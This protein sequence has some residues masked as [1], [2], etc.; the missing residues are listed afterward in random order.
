MKRKT[1][2][3][4][5]IFL[6][7]KAKEIFGGLG[8]LGRGI[9]KDSFNWIMIAVFGAYIGLMLGVSSPYFWYCFISIWLLAC[10]FALLFGGL[11]IAILWG[12]CNWIWDNCKEADKISKERKAEYA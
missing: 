12:F 5:L 11:A 7:L 1:T 4:V 2:N 6:G 10:I 3:V 9:F 8:R